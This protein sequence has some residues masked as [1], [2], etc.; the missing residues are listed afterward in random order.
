MD[1][2]QEQNQNHYQQQPQNQGN[3]QQNQYQAN[4]YSQYNPQGQ[5]G[6]YTPYNQPGQYSQ[7]GPYS[8]Q[9]PYQPFPPTVNITNINLSG[10]SSVSG[11]SRWLAFIL[12]F[13]LGY[14][15]IHR[16]YTGKI[17]TGLLYL[18]TAGFGG[19]GVLIDLIVIATGSFRD[20]YGYYLKS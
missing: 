4:Q 17:G 15:G 20:S 9:G 7:P 13:F 6:Q 3:N 5:P 16:F 12:C 2:D 19:L 11:K 18:F 14:L 1:Y 10:T 8:P